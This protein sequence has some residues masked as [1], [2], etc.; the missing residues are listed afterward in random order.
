MWGVSA[1]FV[2]QFCMRCQV[3][4]HRLSKAEGLSLRGMRP[5]CACLPTLP[6]EKKERPS[7]CVAV[8]VA[9]SLNHTKCRL[10]V[11]LFFVG[12]KVS[13]SGARSLL[14]TC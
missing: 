11:S 12:L 7:E 5:A 6:R 2:L 13:L 1:G 8:S 4:L 9:L 3:D 10:N 14:S